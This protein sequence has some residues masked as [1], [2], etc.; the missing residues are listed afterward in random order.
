MKLTV[1]LLAAALAGCVAIPKYVPPPASGNARITVDAPNA[2]ISVLMD[3]ENCADARMFDKEDNPSA[4]ADRTFT[5][6]ANRKIGLYT[7]WMNAR[8]MCKVMFTATL[9]PD[10]RYLLSG[11]FDGGKCFVTLL[12]ADGTPLGDSDGQ[13]TQVDFGAFGGCKAK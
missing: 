5:V 12:N 7:Q 13:L 2:G 9:K 10:R 6:E 11:Q 4:R 1:L 3:G 8:G